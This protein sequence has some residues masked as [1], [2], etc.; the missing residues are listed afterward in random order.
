M[1]TNTRGADLLVAA[2]S[3]AQVANVFTLSGNQIM[4]V[5]D[6][7]FDSELR[8]IHVRHEAAAVH[9]ADAWGRLT[10]EPG[11]ALVTAG[12]GFANTLS[13]LY[14]ASMAESPLVL[15][16]GH[17]PTD[18]LGRG[19]FQEM[20][21][22]EMAAHVCKASWMVSNSESI[23]HD[24]ARAFRVARSGK[25]GPVHLALPFDLLNVHPAGFRKL[26]P[27]D[28]DFHSLVCLLDVDSARNILAAT[29]AASRPLIL[30]GPASMRGDGPKLLESL[31]RATGVP[32]VATESPRGINDPSLRRFAD[33]LAE[34]DLV[35]L[36]GKQLDFTLRF[37]AAPTF[38]PDCRFIHIDSDTRALELSSHNL[39]RDRLIGTELA[40][41]IPAFERLIQLAPEFEWAKSSW[42]SDVQSA[43]AN[44]P[45]TEPELP[46]SSA[47]RLHAAEVCR[48]I[49]EFLAPSDDSVF[50]SDGGEFGQW[51]QACIKAPH[52]IIN[53]PSGAIGSAI[54]FAMAARLAFPESV[55]V[56]TLGDGTF[57]FHPFEFD[58]AVRYDLP[59]VAVVGN[60]ACW[61]AEHQIQLR[62][63]GAER[64]HSCDLNATPYHEVVKALGGYG[65]SVTNLKTFQPALKRALRSKQ[66]A[67]LNVDI[68]RDSAPT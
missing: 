58:T 50:V 64:T 62:D 44:Q 52:R 6:A 55:I 63:Y 46:S 43:I 39:A 48:G 35:L 19:A 24:F 68:E 27:Q 16:S 11:V 45:D 2:M 13:A 1:S 33:V 67:C 21:Q 53:G 5:F 17:A 8:L 47:G 37:G 61:N 51:A 18:Q 14:V 38:H 41:A 57:G 40:D 26:I 22:T 65:E 30:V 56:A 59:F 9:M 23:G 3:R 25:P 31:S 12:P 10:T 66:P 28:S 20:A 49:N 4:P 32:A 29:R 54:P 60:D 15:I 36:V 34:A 42:R 7:S